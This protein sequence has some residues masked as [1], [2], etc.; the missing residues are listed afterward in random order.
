MAPK[1]RARAITIADKA[2]AQLL[3]SV[4]PGSVVTQKRASQ[5]QTPALPTP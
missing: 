2:T 1:I 5:P 4:P 3:Y